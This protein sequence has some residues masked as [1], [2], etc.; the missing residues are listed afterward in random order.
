MIFGRPEDAG[1]RELHGT[2]AETL[3]DAVAEIEGAEFIDAGHGSTPLD[4]RDAMLIP[5]SLFDNYVYSAQVVRN[6]EQ[7]IPISVT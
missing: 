3:H 6:C 1:S 7:W 2:I 5:A 4:L